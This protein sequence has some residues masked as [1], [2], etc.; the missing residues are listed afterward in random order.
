MHGIAELIA[1]ASLLSNLPGKNREEIKRL[2]LEHPEW[3][4]DEIAS[5]LS[6]KLTRERVRQ[7]LVKLQL[8]TRHTP[9]YECV[10]CKGRFNKGRKSTCTRGCDERFRCVACHINIHSVFSNCTSCGKTVRRGRALSA[11]SVDGSQRRNKSLLSLG[12]VPEEHPA[13]GLIFCDRKC[14][15]HWFGSNH[16]AGK[17]A[18]AGQK[19]VFKEKSYKKH[20]WHIATI[21]NDHF[22]KSNG[23]FGYVVSCNCGIVLHP[24][25][26]YFD[27]VPEGK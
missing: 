20:F 27:A 17:K 9:K 19:I 5:S 7:I 10:E 8:P 21:I 23:K 18:S 25:A 24:S 2:R 16:G 15:G 11:Q 22:K 4:L 3:T 26:Q 1:K 12:L 6:D 13:T 14:Q